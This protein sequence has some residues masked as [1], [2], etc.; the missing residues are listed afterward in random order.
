MV[1]VVVVSMVAGG[2]HGGCGGCG[3]RSSI[4]FLLMYGFIISI[5]E[6]VVNVGSTY[7]YC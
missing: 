3:N 6:W 7:H 5:G 2:N 1:G 4:L